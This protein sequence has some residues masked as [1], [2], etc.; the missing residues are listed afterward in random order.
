M[1]ITL[2]QTAYQKA[3]AHVLEDGT[4]VQYNKID[5]AAA[6]DDVRAARE[7]Y[8]HNNKSDMWHL[9]RI[10]MELL[11]AIRIENKLPNTKEG[12]E[13]ALK[14]VV[15]MLYNGQLNDFKVHGEL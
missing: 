11:D 15:N 9:G 5:M 2:S 8:H 10:P 14:K 3:G 12:R 4:I 1:D 6:K 13:A 7:A